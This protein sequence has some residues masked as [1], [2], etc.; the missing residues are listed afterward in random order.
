MPEDDCSRCGVD[1]ER[2][3]WK[4]DGPCD[5]WVCGGCKLEGHGRGDYPVRG[6]C[7]VILREAGHA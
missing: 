6:L 4:C 7:G 5:R 2:D 1:A 3:G